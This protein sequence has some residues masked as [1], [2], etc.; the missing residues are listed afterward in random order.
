M[1][2]RTWQDTLKPG[3]TAPG[4]PWCA[5]RSTNGHIV[6]TVTGHWTQGE[7]LAAVG[8]PP[9][10]PNVPW[11]NRDTTPRPEREL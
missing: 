4:G 7:A 5:S 2:T 3:E 9:I 11:D 6:Q 8:T 10:D 1:N